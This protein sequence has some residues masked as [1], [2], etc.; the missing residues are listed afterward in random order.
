MSGVWLAALT[1]LYP[2]VVHFAHGRVEPRWLALVLVV[3]GLLRLPSA[4]K[5]P[6]H[7]LGVALP[8]LLAAVTWFA[9]GALPAR[10]YPV[11]VNLGMLILFGWTLLR[12]PSMVERIARL[13][14][15]DLPPYGIVYTRR[16]TQV[17]VAYF[18]INGSIA[19]WTAVWGS[20]AIWTLYNGLISYCVM[21]VLFGG[22]WLVR[23]HVRQKYA[24]A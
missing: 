21:G 2:F 18:I 15:P 20:Q 23:R 13:T 3:V 7:W 4:L 9:N 12:P 14:E 16:V 6:I 22:E 19:F 17:W 1:L 8:L 11:A 24:N 5:T 10:M